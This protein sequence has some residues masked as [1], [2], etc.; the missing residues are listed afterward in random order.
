M[1][2]AKEHAKTLGYALVFLG[3]I[4]LVALIPDL[5]TKQDHNSAAAVSSAKTIEQILQKRKNFTERAQ[6]RSAQRLVNILIVPGHD[7]EYWGTHH[8]NLKEVELNRQLAEN[9]YDYL[10][11]EE[12]INAVL[13]SDRSGYN[14]IFDAYFKRERDDIA[15][16]IEET[17]AKFNEKKESEQLAIIEKNFHNPAPG[18]M[19]LRLYGINRWVNEAD[20][21]L[22]IHI[23]FN[24]HANRNK[25]K[26]GKYTGFSIY[27]PGK[28]FENYE[29]S[30][31]LADSIFNEMKKIRPVSDLPEEEGGVIE[32]YELIALGANES[33]D[34]GSVLVEYGYI[35]ENIFTDSSLRKPALDYM[36]YATYVGIKNLLG[37]EPMRKESK[38]VKTTKNKTTAANL[39]WQFQNAIY[40]AYPPAGKSL[41]DC[42]IG[43]YFGKCSMEV[44]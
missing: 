27:T 1:K 22:V 29:L 41:R 32:D 18:D 26:I 12:G 34:A 7:D 2:I 33:L 30:R 37:E 6:G 5:G 21:D 4:A 38:V 13:S 31:R 40:G 35:Y 11:K 28:E 15:K 3:L 10:V 42:P 23:H 17:K 43:G 9:L 39:E 19:A 14:T 8:K 44:R 24:D 20:F 16:F 25:S 36:A